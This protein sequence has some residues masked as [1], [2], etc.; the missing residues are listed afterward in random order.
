MRKVNRLPGKW[1][2]NV[3]F[4]LI[5]IL[6]TVGDQLSK[7]WIRSNLAVWQS[8]PETGF[9]RLIHLRNTGA[10]FGLFRDY[11]FQ[12]TIVAFVGV[13][14]ILFY[15]FFVCPRYPLLKNRVSKV[16]MGLVLGGAIGNLIDRLRFGYVTDFIGVGA[17]PPF[18]VADS[19]ITVGSVV[20]A[21]SLL[22]IYFRQSQETGRDEATSQKN[23]GFTK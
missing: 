4:S 1:W 14:V 17:W 11:S 12:L 8:L 13:A 16:A 2:P 10:S 19:A 7:A 23:S 5:A 9:F 3:V 6:V 21:G 20:F 22:Y 18:N 15:T